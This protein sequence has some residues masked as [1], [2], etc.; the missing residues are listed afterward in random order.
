MRSVESSFI[1]LIDFGISKYYIV[2]GAHI[3][4]KKKRF[5]SGN[6]VFAS[7][8]AFKGL[9]LTRRDDLI[10]L[11][12]LLI[13]FLKGSAKWVEKPHDVERKLLYK[14]IGQAKNKL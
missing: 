1:H 4:R 5:F 13:Y 10:S 6:I 8:N 11:C 3:K 7:K 12:Y 9:E 14:K 2:N